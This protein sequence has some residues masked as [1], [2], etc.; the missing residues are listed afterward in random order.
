[1]PTRTETQAA[2][3][4]VRRKN[5]EADELEHATRAA[6]ERAADAAE[7]AKR[8]SGDFERQLKG[9]ESNASVEIRALNDRLA[10]TIAAKASPMRPVP[11]SR[12]LA[13]KFLHQGTT[14][15]E[16]ERL[17]NYDSRFAELF[18]ILSDAQQMSGRLFAADVRSDDIFGQ[19]DAVECAAWRAVVARAM[20]LAGESES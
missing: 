20:V 9:C 19:V 5:Q 11:E 17:G 7:I 2:I 13:R 6:R 8:S 14:Y 4:E 12:G 1:M 18:G 3:A 10:R 15:Q 16:V